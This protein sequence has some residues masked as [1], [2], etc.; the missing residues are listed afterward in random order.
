MIRFLEDLHVL[1]TE[2]LQKIR[3]CSCKLIFSETFTEAV[4]TE[5]LES[6]ERAAPLCVCDC[7][8]CVYSRASGHSH[9][10]VFLFSQ[11][12][13]KHRMKYNLVLKG[14]MI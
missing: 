7:L 9:D 12:L 5:H 13:Y 11:G 10:Q 8:T 4:N 6:Q 1:V 3:L 14:F 2:T